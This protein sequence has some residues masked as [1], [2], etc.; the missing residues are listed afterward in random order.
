MLS[1]RILIINIPVVHKGFLDFISKNKQNI[2]EIFLID[3]KLAEKLSDIK[4]DIASIDPKD[5]KKLLNS[6]GIKK[7]SVIK[8]NDFKKIGSK[9]IM[10][11]NDQVSRALAE[12]FLPDADILWKDVFL[13]WD[14][15]SVLASHSANETF[16]SE[17]EDELMMLE[18]YK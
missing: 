3:N 9:K 13:R 14:K 15:D 2:S 1:K 17:L 4:T 16:S 6:L 11:V 8:E 5:S 18:A 7:I 12:K 10:L